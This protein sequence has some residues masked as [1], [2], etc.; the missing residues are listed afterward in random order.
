MRLRACPGFNGERCGVLTSHRRCPDCS[1]KQERARGTRQERGYGSEH[2]ALRASWQ[3]VVDAGRAR[4][5]RGG[6]PIPAGGAF[7]LD[8][9][10]DRTGYIGVSC[11]RH[12]TSAGG[13]ASH[14]PAK[15]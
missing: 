11:P 15:R 9:N 1:A 8:H 13:V 3:A 14:D 10:D 6:E 12:N 2:D 7:H 5:A 4:C